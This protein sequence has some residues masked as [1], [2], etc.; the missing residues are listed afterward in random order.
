LQERM[1][2]A[3][4]SSSPKFR[5][6]WS[7]RIGLIKSDQLLNG[8]FDRTNVLADLALDPRL[9]TVLFAPTWEAG[10]A[11]RT[12]GQEI[13]Q[14][15]AQE[16]WNTIVKLHPMSYFPSTEV[17]ATGGV[18]WKDAFTSLESDRFR[19]SPRADVSPLLAA[20]DVLV[21]DISS[22]AFEAILVD[23]PVVF[24]DCPEFMSKNVR[25][26]YGISEA[27]ARND[28]RYNCGREAGEVARSL[29]ELIDAIQNA[30]DDPEK[31]AA[32]RGEVREQLVFNPG[33]AAT[34]AADAFAELLGT[35]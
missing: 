9:P 27:E 7:R 1:F 2:E 34:N 12:Q 31:L 32:K 16:S 35:S 20:A 23:K 5:R 25:E 13:C 29:D 8:G 4:R 18:D 33:Q 19:H 30:I 11:L 26:M 15:L 24:I 10:A 3:F 14:R 17:F 22:V 6:L 21:T 28:L